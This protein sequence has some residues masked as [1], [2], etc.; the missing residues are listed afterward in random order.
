MA[1]LPNHE[2]I[3]H[4]RAGD[5]PQRPDQR[6][7]AVGEDVPVEVGRDDDVVGGWGA[8]ELVDHAVDD[9][10]F[11]ADAVEGGEGGAGGFAEEAVGLGEDVAFV[12]DGHSGGRVDALRRGGG[13][14]QLLSSDGDF[15]CHVC[16]P[17]ACARAYS[18]DGF[19][20]GAL[21]VGR[22]EGA[23]FFDVQIFCVFS[24]DDEVDFPAAMRFHTADAFHGPHVGVE[25][26][27]FAEGDDGR[28]VAF[29]FG[30]GGGDGAEEGGVA[31]GAEV[32]DGGWGECGAGLAEVGVAAGEGGEVEGEGVGFS[33]GFEDAAAGLGRGR[34]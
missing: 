8:E 31:V 7:G 5:E 23:L 27:L 9:L 21:P 29:D 13:G 11:D 2:P 22:G 30:G 16:D 3:A 15:A 1:R 24:Y 6:G 4:V 25:I 18:L 26:E 19:G 17:A 33:E 12:G 34:D 10:L 28:G 32:V 20:Y 14:P